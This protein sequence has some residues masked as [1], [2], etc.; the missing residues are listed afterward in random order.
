MRWTTHTCVR[1]AITK[2]PRREIPGR[3]CSSNRCPRWDSN[4]H[5]ADFEAASSTNWDTGAY[6]NL[7]QYTTQSGLIPT[8][9]CQ[10]LSQHPIQYPI[11][12]LIRHPNHSHHSP[13]P[14]ATRIPSPATHPPSHRTTIHGH[15]LPPP[16]PYAS[17]RN[18]GIGHELSEMQVRLIID[19]LYQR[20]TERD[21][22]HRLQIMEPVDEQLRKV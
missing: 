2:K 13:Q 11:Q 22:R 15:T 9:C 14:T 18:R 7:E 6:L 16:A 10:H 8:P 5:C 21:L 4:P 1:W 20:R 19:Q 12:R 17:E 3:G